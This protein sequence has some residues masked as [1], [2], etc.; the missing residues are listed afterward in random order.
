MTFRDVGIDLPD[1]FSG[2]K[3]VLCPRC[4]HTR[5]HASEPCLSVNGE[6]GIWH[7]HN[8]GW[9]GSLERSSYK[10]EER[11]FR[12]PSPVKID[13]VDSHIV[14]YFEG[15]GIGPVTLQRLKIFTCDHYLPG[16]GEET[17]C[18]AFPYYKNGELV[19]IKYR[20]AEKNM[21]QEKDPEPCLYNIDSTTNVETV[22]VAE[23][24]IDVATLVENGF[25]AAVSVDKG[26]PQVNDKNVDKKLECVDRCLELL[27][28]VKTFVLC[29]DKDEPGLRLEREL[30]ARFGAERCRTTR[31]PGGCKDIN[32]VLVKHGRDAVKKVIKEAEKCPVPG[33]RKFSDFK[34]KIDE[35]YKHGVSRGKSTGWKEFDA[36]FT[37]KTGTINVITGVPQS[38]KSEWMNALIVNTMELHSW[39]WVVFSPEMLPPETLFSNFAEKIV[40]RPFFG[41]K[42]VRMD[43]SDIERAY[44]MLEDGITIIQPEDEAVWSLENVLDLARVAIVRDNVKGVLID[45]WNELEVAI[46]AGMSMTDYTGALLQK[47]RK[48]A[49]RY[50][51]W[52]GIVAHPK[53]LEKDKSGKIPVATLSDISGSQN[54][55]NKADYGLSLYRDKRE[56]TNVVEVHVLK[57]KNKYVATSNTITNFLLYYKSGR[58]TIMPDY[59][60][61]T[62]IKVEDEE[63][64]IDTDLFE[65]THRYSRNDT[66]LPYKEN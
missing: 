28:G 34:E 55:A 35:F 1:N 18:I 12:R 44:R 45:P 11:I 21:S 65:N 13:G 54:F 5:K 17:L 43:A 36:V 46:P 19:N 3:K 51:V 30:I 33:L 37:L 23:G 38:G 27:Q 10:S 25:F 24:E 7:C 62:A 39:K 53:K 52:L 31:Y 58:F 8:C 22:Y 6:K 9:D 64:D 41:K 48:F 4:S 40:R 56:K 66:Y 20:D 2:D 47:A 50:D 26:A 49:R 61:N 32:E 63:E 42:D 57:A 14:Q 59:T 15:R 29:S 60:E 16:R